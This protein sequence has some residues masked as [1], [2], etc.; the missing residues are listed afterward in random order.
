MEGYD[1]PDRLLVAVD[2]LV[3]CFIDG[4]LHLLITRNQ[5][6]RYHH[7]WSLMGDFILRNESLDEAAVRILMQ[8]T[9]VSGVYLEQFRAF[10]DIDRDKIE[11]TIS[12]AYYALV[13]HADVDRQITADYQARWVPVYDLPPLGF[14]HSEM[15]T[16]ALRRLRYRAI[17]EPVILQMLG[18][19]FTLTEL[20]AAYESIFQ[21]TIDA[22]NFRRR[23]R[24]MNYLEQLDEKDQRYSK[25]GAYLYRFR[26]DLFAEAVAGGAEFLLK[27]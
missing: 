16:A 4:R 24:R 15:V 7:E 8:L 20:Q 17:H 6:P 19:R 11:R 12:V 5:C 25:K 9:G 18:D 1:H 26:E 10:G 21:T 23:L 2:C 14:D 27:P 13:N 22:G 3:F